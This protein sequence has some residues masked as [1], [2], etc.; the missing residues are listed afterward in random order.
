MA[1]GVVL[2]DS[3]GGRARTAVRW[4]WGCSRTEPR[5]GTGPHFFWALTFGDRAWVIG[6]CRSRKCGDRRSRSPHPMSPLGTGPRV[7]SRSPVPW[8]R[9][10]AP[11]HGPLGLVAVPG[12][13]P[14]ADVGPVALHFSRRHR[15]RDLLLR[16]DRS[17]GPMGALGT[18]PR[19]PIEFRSPV[20]KFGPRSPGAV[21]ESGLGPRRVVV[22]LVPGWS[23]Q[24]GDRSLPSV[25]ASSVPGVGHVPPRSVPAPLRSPDE[26]PSEVRPPW[27]AGRCRFRWAGGVVGR[28]RRG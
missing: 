1:C 14:D 7:R 28:G 4:G 16:R 15:P 5:V 11:V 20:P 25:P 13:R 2:C 9:S 18:G 12:L 26:S 21:P 27:P 22:A 10:P 23:P 6:G 19:S 24:L 8:D 3:W 17:P